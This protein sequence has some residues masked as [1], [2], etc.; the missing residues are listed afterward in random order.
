MSLTIEHTEA[1]GTILDGTSRG[2]GSGDVVKALGWRWSRQITSW[3]IPRSRDVPPKRHLIARTADALR[4]A[5][6][7]VDVV[8][9]ATIDDRQD[10]EARRAER[11]Q[12]RAQRLT[13]KADAAQ[14]RADAHHD[15]AEQISHRFVQGQ[16]I[17]IGHHSQ[18]SAERDAERIRRSITASVEEQ[19]RAHQARDS[20]AIAAAATDTRNTPTVVAGRIDRLGAQLRREERDLAHYD[21]RGADPDS[22]RRLAMIESIDFLRANIDH[23]QAVR[24]YQIATGTATNYSAATVHKGDAVQIGGTWYRVARANTKTVSVQTGHS[25]TRKTPWHNVKDHRPAD[26]EATR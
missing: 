26:H 19:Q 16:P 17:L 4:A 11:A 5:G 6:F 2:D 9:D 12:D 14:Q 25:W 10:A 21:G 23:W 1:E 20:A 22:V 24:D 3:Y 15:K 7:D 13:A 8:V 18:A